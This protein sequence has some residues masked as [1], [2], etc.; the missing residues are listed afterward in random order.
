M[1][2]IRERKR[3]VLP[4]PKGG[5]SFCG[6][7]RAGGDSLG[8]ECHPAEKEAAESLRAQPILSERNDGRAARVSPSRDVVELRVGEGAHEVE[9]VGEVGEASLNE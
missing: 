9:R 1:L 3:K 7:P 8:K 6:A 5:V 4:V 2:E